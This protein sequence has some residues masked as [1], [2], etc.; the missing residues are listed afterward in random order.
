M[1]Q[2]QFRLIDHIFSSLNHG[3]NTFFV[4]ASSPLPARANPSES[5]QDAPALSPNEKR[6]SAG[7]MRVNHCGEVCAQALY[8]GQS[9]MTKDPFLRQTFLEAAKEEKDHL[10]WCEQRLI[11]LE[12]HKSYLNPLW[13]TGSLMIGICTSFTENGWNLGF[14][15]ETEHQV[16]QHLEDH[17]TKLP[18][19]DLK[20]RAIV[21]Q[22]QQDETKHQHTAIMLGAKTL[23]YP[24]K[25]SMTAL[26]K[27]MTTLAYY[28]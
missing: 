22:M 6:Q 13:Y 23:P 16:A 19:H 17:L 11:E 25:A 28:F 15:A 8:I 18:P 7:L 26:S 27:V 4:K 12:S 10:H 20:S 14:L 5:H 9:L 1:S 3:L 21:L 24:I 2:R